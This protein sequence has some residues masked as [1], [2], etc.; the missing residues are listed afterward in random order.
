MAL[1]QRLKPGLG[2]KSRLGLSAGYGAHLLVCNRDK[3][4][5]G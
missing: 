3:S 5:L 4:L 2:V 1:N